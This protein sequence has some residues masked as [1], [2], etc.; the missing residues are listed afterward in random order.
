MPASVDQ[1]RG[2][3]A[4]PGAGTDGPDCFA[5]TVSGD[6]TPLAIYAR[7]STLLTDLAYHRAPRGVVIPR[8]FRAA[9]T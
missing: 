9:A 6:V 4:T 7:A 3:S 5:L 8:A 1:S 2:V